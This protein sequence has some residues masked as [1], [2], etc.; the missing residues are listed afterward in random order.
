MSHMIKMLLTAEIE[1][2]EES[3]KKCVGDW[4]DCSCMLVSRYVFHSARKVMIEMTP[5]KTL[6]II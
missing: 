5:F 2:S 6:S 1:E 3:S 4:C